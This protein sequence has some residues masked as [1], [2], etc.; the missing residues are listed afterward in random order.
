MDGWVGYHGSSTK[1]KIIFCK[2]WFAFFFLLL[3][4]STLKYLKSQYHTGRIEINCRHDDAQDKLIHLYS[5]AMN[6]LQTWCANM[7]NELQRKS[8]QFSAK[9]ACML[10]KSLCMHSH[11]YVYEPDWRGMYYVI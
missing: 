10:C 6:L 2:V 4:T 5:F 8:P 3:L 11:A 7:L 9:L 1:I